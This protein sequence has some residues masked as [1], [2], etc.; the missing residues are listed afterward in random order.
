MSDLRGS[1]VQHFDIDAE[2]DVILPPSWQGLRQQIVYLAQFGN[3]IQVIHAELGGGKTT[4]FNHLQAAG[5]GSTTI[6]VTVTAGAGLVAFLGD[7]LREA[8]LRPDARATLEELAAS[9]RGYVQ[10]LHRERLRAVLL[11]DDAHRLADSELGA[12]VSTLQGQADHGVGL[13]V[14][15]FSEPGLAARI[16]SLQVLDVA[17]HDAPLP[18]FSVF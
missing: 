4:F 9:L 2:G 14:V 5:L 11:V 16:D 17:V 6:G 18:L 15:L 1:K 13:H 8:G 10:T 12:L 3:S 7:V